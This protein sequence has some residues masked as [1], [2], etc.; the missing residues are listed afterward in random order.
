[1]TREEIKNKVI[2]IVASKIG[3]FQNEIKE[4]TRFKADLGTD[5]LDDIELLMEFE[6]VFGIKIP[7]EEMFNIV[8]VGDVINGLAARFGVVTEEKEQQPAELDNEEIELSDFESELF[9]VFSDAWQ[10][11]LHG[12][13]VDMAQWAKEHS[14]Q[15]LN[16][17]KQ[18]LK[19]TEWS[20]ED[21]RMLE[22]IISDLRE[23]CNCETDEELISDYEDRIAWLISLRP[24]PH[25]KPSEYT[26]S[27]VKKVADGEMLTG[28][29]QMAMET[30]CDDL[31]KL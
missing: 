8:T 17:A 27:L 19:P 18:E 22:P 13:E 14:A 3:F 21:E 4:S 25:W 31:K 26:L 5:S 30:L 10:Q 12:E 7:D 11:Y 1:M 6:N 15:L 20:E 28:M 29:E 16:A 2:E 9:S 24:H 23:L